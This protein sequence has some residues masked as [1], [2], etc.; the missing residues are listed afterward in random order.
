[1]DQ[2]DSCS[3]GAVGSCH[4]KSA[5]ILL[6]YGFPPSDPKASIPGENY[7]VANTLLIRAVQLNPSHAE[8]CAL[9]GNECFQQKSY[10]E[11]ISMY[12][13]CLRFCENLEM[14]SA[15]QCNLE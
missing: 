11:A 13:Q 10:G 3:P 15:V 1:M 8:A 12:K 2:S 6:K 14:I 7:R 4:Y 9:R 5:A